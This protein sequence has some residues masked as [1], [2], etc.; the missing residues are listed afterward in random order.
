MIMV[1]N[2]TMYPKRYGVS[3]LNAIKGDTDGC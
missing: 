1:H 2:K 3:R